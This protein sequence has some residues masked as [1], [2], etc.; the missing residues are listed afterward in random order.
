[1]KE[2]SSYTSAVLLQIFEINVR[3]T[4]F[5]A[6]P[7]PR[8]EVT[9]KTRIRRLRCVAGHENN[10]RRTRALIR[11]AQKPPVLNCPKTAQKSIKD[12]K[13]VAGS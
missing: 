3:F 10:N 11:H 9:H 5:L 12:E 8:N 6:S 4:R 13:Q 1:M 2:A 7:L